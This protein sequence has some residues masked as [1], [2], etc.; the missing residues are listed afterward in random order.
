MLIKRVMISTLRSEIF[1]RFK[2]SRP[3]VCCFLECH[4]Q[5]LVASIF[6]AEDLFTMKIDTARFSE[7]NY[8][9]KF[10]LSRA[11]TF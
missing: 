7:I 11:K 4:K 10:S 5:E 6:N 9:Y 1:V 2:F 8:L 3:W